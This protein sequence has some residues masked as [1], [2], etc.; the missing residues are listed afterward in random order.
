MR[1]ARRSTELLGMHFRI[2]I[3][4][5]VA[6]VALALGVAAVT[7]SSSTRNTL[8]SQLQRP[9]STHQVEL[10]L[11]TDRASLPNHLSLK[12]P[13]DAAR[14]TV[15]FSM[16]SM[17]MWNGLSGTLV[18]TGRGTYSMNV[19]VLGMPG[20]WMMQFHVVPRSG[21]AYTVSVDKQLR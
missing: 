12:L 2:L 17:N 14:V 1:S 4:S 16:P 21:A 8:Y 15:S 18:P 3:A 10:A 13:V 6:L 20:T 9:A 19:P 5:A 7:A 11:A